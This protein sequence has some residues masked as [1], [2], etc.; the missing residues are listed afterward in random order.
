MMTLPMCAWLPGCMHHTQVAA[1]TGVPGVCTG[2]AW[3]PSGGE[4]L[5]IECR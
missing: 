3:K 2:L 1:R 4:L 5:F